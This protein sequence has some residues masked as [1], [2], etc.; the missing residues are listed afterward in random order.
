MCVKR[1]VETGKNALLSV[2]GYETW[3]KLDLEVLKKMY[4]RR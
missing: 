1:E 4:T 2:D 3:E